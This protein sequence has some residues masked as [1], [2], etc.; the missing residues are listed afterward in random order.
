MIGEQV[1]RRIDG[2]SD[3]STVEKEGTGPRTAPG[4]AD[5]ISVLNASAQAILLGS[6]LIEIDLGLVGGG[7]TTGVIGHHTAVVTDHLIAA[8]ALDAMGEVTILGADTM[9]GV[10]GLPEGTMIEVTVL[11]EGMMIEVMVLPEGM[12]IEVMGRQ[13]GMMTEGAG[14]LEDMT[15]MLL[16]VTRPREMIHMEPMKN[17]MHPTDRI[18]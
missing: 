11:P 9:T 13:G 3:A 14:L 17:S 5:A 16:L 18:L 12:M 10:M 6:A 8:E 2:M 7:G 1:V 15:S 4:H